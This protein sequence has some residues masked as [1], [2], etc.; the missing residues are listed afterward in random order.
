MGCMQTNPAI[1][2]YLFRF[3][4]TMAAYAAALLLTATAWMGVG[5]PAA[6]GQAAAS[7]PAAP[8]A[9]TTPAAATQPAATAA[10][11]DLTFDVAS[12]RPSAPLDHGE[13]DGGDAGG[14]DAELRHAP[15]WP[16]RRV[17]LHVVE[18]TDRRGLQ[19]EAVPGHLCGLDQQAGRAALRHRGAL[20]RRI[21]QRKTQRPC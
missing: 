18:G 6:L 16:A 14:Q 1:R 9:A 21:E 10:A 4:P 15:G 17:Q 2:R 11:S 7:A 12:V 5:A 13:V 20:A 3:V 19:G 8:A